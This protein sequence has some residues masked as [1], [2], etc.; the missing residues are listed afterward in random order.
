MGR[1]LWLKETVPR[2]EDEN[3][4]YFVLEIPNNGGP[5]GQPTYNPILSG[6]TGVDHPARIIGIEHG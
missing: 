5:P 6:G 4:V 1:T 3:L 2:I